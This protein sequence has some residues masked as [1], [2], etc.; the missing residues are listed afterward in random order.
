MAGTEST[1]KIQGSD[2]KNQGS[3]NNAA[4]GSVSSAASSSQ[5]IQAALAPSS[6]PNSNA[7]VKGMP[8]KTAG[9][10]GNAAQVK[11]PVDAQKQLPVYSNE[12]IANLLKAYGITEGV[13]G[14]ISHD[15]LNTHIYFYSLHSLTSESLLNDQIIYFLY[16]RQRNIPLQNRRV[17]FLL[18]QP[19]TDKPMAFIVSLKNPDQKIIQNMQDELKH[20]P[21]PAVETVKETA[22]FQHI[23]MLYKD[24]CGVFL[25]GMP[26]S[27]VIQLLGRTLLNPAIKAAYR[28]S[29]IDFG[30]KGKEHT[31]VLIA[32]HMAQLLMT[33]V[34]TLKTPAVLYNAQRLFCQQKFL[35][36]LQNPAI[37]SRLFILMKHVLFAEARERLIDLP[38]GERAAGF[39]KLKLQCYSTEAVIKEVD[40]NLMLQIV[41]FSDIESLLKFLELEINNYVS[42]LARWE[43][44]Y[45]PQQSWVNFFLETAGLVVNTPIAQIAGLVVSKK[46]TKQEQKQVSSDPS[47][48][49]KDVINVT[50][51]VK[52]GVTGLMLSGYLGSYL[53]LSGY[54]LLRMSFVKILGDVIK[55]FLAPHCDDKTA[56][57][58]ISRYQ[59]TVTNLRFEIAFITLELIYN[60]DIR[61][62]LNHAA[63][64]N[65]AHAVGGAFSGQKLTKN[66]QISLLLL[67][68]Y[69]QFI[70]LMGIESAYQQVTRLSDG[71]QRIGARLQAEMDNFQEELDVFDVDL[72]HSVSVEFRQRVFH[73]TVFTADIQQPLEYVE[74]WSYPRVRV[75]FDVK[76][77]GRDSFFHQPM[78][79]TVQPSISNP[80]QCRLAPVI[81]GPK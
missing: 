19:D 49:V 72:D 10:N 14:D 22:A 15:S 52:V 5:T 76:W 8:A 79:C 64:T 32:D 43:K 56:T 7:D 24:V 51:F 44:R 36:L 67:I 46:E 66:D 31:G 41:K 16:C 48:K 58:S 71:F 39:K 25:S 35:S 61:Y 80:I 59:D 47:L 2:N 40:I 20:D 30:D 78:E 6:S 38:I 74:Q 50:N 37:G 28:T 21:N 68:L 62:F 1:E 26:T 23:K 81:S 77:S 73:D 60:R 3:T 34:N 69:S 18:P 54:S 57:V 4:A 13:K 75:E 65:V 11:Q 70:A 12:M 27:E 42:A 63:A 53:A 17:G 29:S 55:D 45:L 33:G 9:S